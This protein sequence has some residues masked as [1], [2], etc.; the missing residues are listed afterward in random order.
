MYLFY[1]FQ[2]VGAFFLRLYF[3]VEIGFWVWKNILKGNAAFAYFY[4]PFSY[5]MDF[6]NCCFFCG[7]VRESC[8]Q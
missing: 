5:R 4:K 1:A 6:S 8:G 3:G 7:P 2:S